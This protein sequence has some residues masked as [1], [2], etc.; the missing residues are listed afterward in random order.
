VLLLESHDDITAVIILW[1]YR[2]QRRR[3]RRRR[4][5]SSSEMEEVGGRL[6]WY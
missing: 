2:V 4:R 1:G 5:R 3:R 6:L